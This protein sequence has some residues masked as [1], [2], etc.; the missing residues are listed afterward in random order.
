LQE[1]VQGFRLEPKAGMNQAKPLFL[2][3]I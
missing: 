1:Q 2:A 3:G